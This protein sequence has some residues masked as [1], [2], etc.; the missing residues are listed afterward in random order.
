MRSF[1]CDVV[2]ACCASSACFDEESRESVHESACVAS[3]IAVAIITQMPCLAPPSPATYSTPCAVFVRRE[4]KLYEETYAQMYRL[5]AGKKGLLRDS[6]SAGVELRAGSQSSAAAGA[7][8]SSTSAARAPRTSAAPASSS[9]RQQHQQQQQHHHAASAGS[10]VHTPAAA[11][12]ARGVEAS[13]AA[14]GVRDDRPANAASV[15]EAPFAAASGSGPLAVGLRQYE[16]GAGGGSDGGGGRVPQQPQQQKAAGAGSGNVP[17]TAPTAA[18]APLAV[19]ASSSLLEFQPL[20][21]QTGHAGT[22][23]PF[24]AQALT[25]PFTAVGAAAPLPMQLPVHVPMHVAGTPMV[26]HLSWMHQQQLSPGQL[27]ELTQQLALNQQQLQQQHQQ[28]H[29]QGPD[30]AGAATDTQM[31]S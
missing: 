25:L 3:F 5:V 16:E 31:S 17:P 13:A 20:Q 7:G 23:I 21:P 18:D 30:I 29:H 24:G 28:P 22:P 15:S 19:S 26:Q 4:H 11:D 27:K 2:V 1:V 10:S 12:A 6:I 9:L 14:G 8:A